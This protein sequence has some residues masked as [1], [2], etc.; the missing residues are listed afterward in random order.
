MPTTYVLIPTGCYAGATKYNHIPL[1]RAISNSLADSSK[2]SIKLIAA[3]QLAQ[4]LPKDDLLMLV[5]AFDVVIQ[6]LLVPGCSIWTPLYN[7]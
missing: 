5:D 2:T 6:V 1:C 3:H 7:I 4:T